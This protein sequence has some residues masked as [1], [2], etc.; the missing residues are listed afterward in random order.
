MP[1]PR[2]RL[3]NWNKFFVGLVL[4]LL[5]LAALLV[6]FPWDWLREPLNRRISTQ[7]G[8]HFEIT[9]KLHV[10]LGRTTTVF[11]DGIEIANPPWARDPFLLKAESAEF[12]IRVWP[13]LTGRVYIP[14]ISL[15][16]PEIG[17]EI[18]QQGRRTWG[19]ANHAS[20][21]GPGPDIGS[22][23]MDSGSL[24]YISAAQRADIA[25]KFALATEA[26]SDMP[27]T[28]DAT[29]RWQ[30]ETFT[31]KGRTGSV[32]RLSRDM[33]ARFPVELSAQAGGTRLKVRGSVTD[34][35]SLSAFDANFDLQGQNLEALYKLAGVSLP[36]TPPYKLLGQ[37]T[38]RDE[39][40]SLTEIQGVLGNTD[41]AGN[42]S[43]DQSASTGVLAGKL[44]SKLLDFND[45][46]PL[47]GLPP[48]GKP[49][50]RQLTAARARSGTV[51]AA[52]AGDASASHKVLPS[53]PLDV[54]RLN[55]MNA[56]V[57]Y[58]AARIRHAPALP[59][60]RGSVQ[61]KLTDGLL[62]LNPVSLGVAG[63]TVAGSVKVD[64]RMTP[65]S[66]ATRLDVRG[67]QLNQLFPT[68]ETSKSSLGRVSGQLDLQGRGNSSAEMLASAS[69][70]LSV[71]MG[72]GQISNILLEYLGLDGGEIIKFLVGGDRNVQLR[73]AVAAFDVKQ[74]LMT[75]R[76]LVLDTVDTVIQG[77]G[78]INLA[79]ETLNLRLE[80]A[81][82]DFSILSFRSPLTITGTF[83]SPQAGP[84]KGALAGRGA[85]ALALGL[86]N[87]LLALAA[88]IETGPGQDADCT[89]IFA[90]GKPDQPRAGSVPPISKAVKK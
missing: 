69:G 25:V 85:L 84:D 23:V 37:V 40:W 89:G 3:T 44:H 1:L 82:K 36:A 21:G 53:K 38:K 15:K 10:R 14:R 86:V 74:G 70:D 49:P 8:R 66:L 51:P 12:D 26:S 16:K 60:D 90:Q 28:F 24:Y 45:L 63:G 35:A 65:A 43:F 33:A 62:E 56:N 80:P 5:A 4:L 29:G 55:A 47:V 77:S 71:L 20:S 42:L 2:I 6:F 58:S 13:L 52:R 31:A 19:F 83:A 32:L 79:G 59:L 76:A 67:V 22:I 9:R 78:Q 87:P 68:I 81:P 30:E 48:Q 50:A 18:D 27:L 64:S 34:L 54:P 61:V 72:R 41:M 57:H 17:L 39:L 7:L 88:T 46:A 73:C 11:T 75:S